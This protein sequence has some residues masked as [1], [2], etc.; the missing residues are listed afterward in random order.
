MTKTTKRSKWGLLPIGA[1]ALL[2]LCGT[3]QAAQLP[4]KG[5]FGVLTLPCSVPISCKPE[6]SPWIQQLHN[7][8]YVGALARLLQESQTT[9]NSTTRCSRCTIGKVS[10]PS[11]IQFFSHGKRGYPYI[12]PSSHLL[13]YPS[14]YP[15]IHIPLYPPT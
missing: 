6:H 15:S 1:H 8:S 13:T 2:Q 4:S 3:D 11:R 5:P 7:P 9:K 10:I 12:H 14:F